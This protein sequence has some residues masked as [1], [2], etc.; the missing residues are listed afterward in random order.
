VT[1]WIALLRAVNL[2]ARNKVPMAALR[3]HLAAAGLTDVRTHLQSGNVIVRSDREVAP[4]IRGVLRDR[5]G[6]RPPTGSS[7]SRNGTTCGCSTGR[8]TWTIGTVS[9]A[10]R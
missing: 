3:E 9:T 7:G 10:T 4:V 8:S 2:G 6:V 5:F 1:V